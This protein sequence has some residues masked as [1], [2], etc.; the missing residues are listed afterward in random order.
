M[1]FFSSWDGSGALLFGSCGVF[2]SLTWCW[3]RFLTWRLRLLLK[4]VSK[5]SNWLCL[6]SFALT[7]RV[8]SANFRRTLISTKLPQLNQTRHLNSAKTVI[9]TYQQSKFHCRRFCHTTCHLCG[10]QPNST[11]EIEA[12]PGRKKIFPWINLN[13]FSKWRLAARF[14]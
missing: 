9:E 12:F 5:F 8:K 11:R 2:G 6:V 7:G 4:N 1:V 3:S 14:H 10:R 13:S